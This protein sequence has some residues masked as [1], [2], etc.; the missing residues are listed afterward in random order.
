MEIVAECLFCSK[1]INCTSNDYGTF[2]GHL[3]S[4]H[5][6]SKVNIMYFTKSKYIKFNK[7]FWYYNINL[8]II[9]YSS[10]KKKFNDLSMSLAE[11]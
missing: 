9:L 8:Y 5:K 10:S 2:V 11:I 6:N 7:C 4:K 1:V 3:L